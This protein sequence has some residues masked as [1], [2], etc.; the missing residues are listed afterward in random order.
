MDTLFYY[1]VYSIVVLAVCLRIL[2]KTTSTSKALAYMLLVIVVPLL[3]IFLYFSFGDNYRKKKLYLKKLQFDHESY[4]ELKRHLIDY[5]DEILSRNK[6]RL[7]Y[8]GPLAN[9]RKTESLTSDNNRVSLL[10][11]GESKFSEVI[12]SLKSA[13]NHIHIEYYIFEDD[14]IGNAIGDILIDKAQEGVEVRFIYDDFGSSKMSRK[15]IK[16][17]KQHGVEIKAF[18]KILFIPFA[19]RLNYRNHRKI[20]VIDGDIGFVGGINVSDQYINCGKNKLYWRDTHLKIQGA[21]VL[22]LQYIFLTDWNFCSGQNIAFTSKYFDFRILKETYG[23]QL[24]QIVASGPDSN[25]PNIMYTIIQ[26]I[27]LSKKSIKITTPYFIPDRSF[28][29]AISIAA[30]SDIKIQLILPG[31]SD[32]YIINAASNTYV[33]ELLDIGVE[34]YKYEKGFIHAKTMVC[35]DYVCFIGTANMDNRSFD[36]NFE[37]NALVYDTQLAKEL[38]D[39][40]EQDLKV[41]KQV[42]KIEWERRPLSVQLIEKLVNLFSALM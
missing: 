31:V 40:F 28:I 36:L 22:N 37:V 17:L 42:N 10:I 29:D 6:E 12:K 18:Y 16:K 25:Y 30:L 8:F 33:Q 38:N 27:L 23:N 14:E 34:V 21:S 5:E 24:T 4:T 9:Y 13:K 15:F 32:S 39:N 26:A 41:S 2:F 3:R 19:N 11:N 1:I 20:I 7:S 35:D